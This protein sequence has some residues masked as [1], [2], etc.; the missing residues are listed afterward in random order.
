M[1]QVKITLEDLFDLPTAVIYN[2][3][4]YKPVR[5]VSIDSRTIKKNSLFVA[6]KGEKFDGHNFV[7][8]AVKKGAAAVIIEKKKLKKFDAVSVPIITVDDTTI[9][10][11]NLANIWRHK[12]NAKVVALTGSNGKTTTKEMIAALLSTKYNVIKTEANNNNHIGV[13]LT[14]FNANEKTEVIVLEHGTNHFK[15]IEYTANISEPDLAFITNIGDSHTEFLR[16]R[17]GVFQEKSALLKVTSKCK[18]I[19]LINN[20]DPFIR[21]AKK[22]FTTVITY[23]FKG[24]VDIKGKISGYTEQGLPGVEIE[25]KRKK[26]KVELP[27]HGEANAKNYLAVVAVALQLGLKKNEIIEGTKNINAV[28]GRLNA[29]EAGNTLLIDDSYNSNP[30]SVKAALDVLTKVKK[31]KRKIVLLGDMFELGKNENKM[32][33]DLAEHVIK[34]KIDEV[35]TL[36]T[37]MK[38]LNDNLPNSK[39]TKKFFDKR[40]TL[41][42]F[43]RKIDIDNAVIL[44][45]ASRGMKMEEF[46]DILKAR[47]N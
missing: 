2:P 21:K 19:V 31:Y 44:V 38:N 41:K 33:S 1:K 17:K 35:Y 36:G 32:H 7:N 20:D 40:S 37:R 28:K 46:V 12:L 22:D 42:N 6:V 8:N 13:P 9:A 23:G 34:S 4:D 45:K 10:Y 16:D 3:D 30:D 43:L 26:I 47:I 11:G 15:E 29:V 27:V 5:Y 25:G 14:I 24:N 39:I 18:G